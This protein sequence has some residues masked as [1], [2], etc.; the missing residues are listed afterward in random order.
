MAGTI[1]APAAAQ[2]A[3]AEGHWPPVTRG[4]GGQAVELYWHSTGEVH[5]YAWKSNNVGFEGLPTDLRGSYTETGDHSY[6]FGT[7][8][9]TF[10][11]G[12][13]S[14]SVDSWGVRC[15]DYF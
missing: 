14:G 12:E 7:G 9:H 4:C 6:N 15:V 1:I 2:S 13:S 11:F 8:T 5:L 10:G 3:S